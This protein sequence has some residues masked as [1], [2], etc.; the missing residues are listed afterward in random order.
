LALRKDDAGIVGLCGEG[1]GDVVVAVGR[2]FGRPDGSE[3]HG[4]RLPGG[5]YGGKNMKTL[6]LF[7]G[8][9]I[10]KGCKVKRTV[11]LKDIAPTI[12]HLMGFPVPHD[13]EGGII[14]QMLENK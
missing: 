4:S 3:V 10:R 6:L 5:Q 11:S 9:G 13:T 8:A 7:S 2:G 1:I 14:Y 12:A